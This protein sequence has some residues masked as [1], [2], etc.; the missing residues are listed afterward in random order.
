M[1]TSGALRQV[2]EERS[3][4]ERDGASGGLASRHHIAGLF[5]I[6]LSSSHR[7]VVSWSYVPLSESASLSLQGTWSGSSRTSYVTDAAARC[8]LPSPGVPYSAQSL[9]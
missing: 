1:K 2:P 8:I 6:K 9:T 7:L 3:C 4:A 5:A